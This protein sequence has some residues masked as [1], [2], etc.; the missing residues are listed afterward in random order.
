MSD[1]SILIKGFNTH[2]FDFLD[3]VARI[4][5]NKDI[6]TSKAFFETIKKANPSILIKYWFTHV[7][8]PYKDIIDSGDIDFFINKDYMLDISKLQYYEQIVNAIK[9]IKLSI[10][11]T[12]KIN[13]EHSMKYVQNLSKL[14]LLYNQQ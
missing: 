1:K 9:N 4:I 12:S 10:K 14:S 3:D 13:Q 8:L 5:D 7:Y 11:Q 2:F 6:L